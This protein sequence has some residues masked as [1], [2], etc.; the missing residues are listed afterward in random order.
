VVQNSIN[1]GDISNTWYNNGYIGTGGILGASGFSNN[2]SNLVP[3]SV[4]ISGCVNT[5]AINALDANAGGL[6]GYVQQG[7]KLSLTNSYNWGSVTTNS[8]RANYPITAG[9]IVG[10]VD[11]ATVDYIIAGTYNTGEVSE[12]QT[13]DGTE[14]HIGGFVGYTVASLLSG[15]RN[16]YLD[17]SAPGA[18][19]SDLYDNVTAVPETAMKTSGFVGLLNSG[20]QPGEEPY[21]AVEDDYPVLAWQV[22]ASDNTDSE[23]P[24]TP[25]VPSSGGSSSGGT[26]SGSAT[27]PSGT[28]SEPASTPDDADPEPAE[29]PDETANPNEPPAEGTDNTVAAVSASDSQTQD[30]WSIAV[31]TSSGGSIP[32]G[33]R[34]RV[35]FI[36]AENNS[37]NGRGASAYYGP[38]VTTSAADGTLSVDVNALE[39]PEGE[40]ASIP[41]G[42]YQIK[43]ADDATGSTYVGTTEAVTT[44]GTRQA[45]SSA[46]SS[47]D[48]SGGCDAGFGSLALLAA[49]GT[50]ILRGKREKTDEMSDL[51]KAA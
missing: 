25:S 22:E 49:A 40:K 37:N 6:A 26:D 38:F 30:A 1:N 12:G 3:A 24:S 42:T 15:G 4:A 33:V 11:N 5:G 45:E 48:G 27:V 21:A 50:L 9:G 18:V 8:D 31:T 44:Q 13:V 7:D 10:R 46:S 28:D 34:F 41:A 39:T 47:G 23:T 14:T 43:Y 35:W 51:D 17:S 19:D 29:T 2:T 32:S 20:S 36:A 16:Y